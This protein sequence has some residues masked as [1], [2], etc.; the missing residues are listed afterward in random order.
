ML[1]A[2]EGEARRQAAD[3]R[4]L[5]GREPVLL[6]GREFHWRELAAVSRQWEYRRLEALYRIRQEESPVIV[7]TADALALRCIP[8]QV[9]DRCSFTLR[10]DGRYQVEELARRLTAAGYT[11]TEQVEGPGQF[12]LRGGILD[13]YS[14]GAE[15]PV[16]CEFFDDEVDSL[17][18]FDVATQRRTENCREALLLP[19]GEVLPLWRDGAA[20]ETAERLETLAGRMKD[21]PVARQLR[22]DADLLRQG[23]V[24]NG[25]DRFLAAVYPELV[26]AMDYLPAGCLVCVSES[27][28]TAEA[29]KGWLGQLKAD[30]TAAMDSGILCGPMAEAALPE[31]EFARQLERFPVCQLESLPTSRYLLAPKALLQIDARQLS[32]YGGSLETA[33]TDLTHY[34]TGG[35][36]VV[37]LCGGQVRARNLLELLEARRIPAVLDLEGER[38]PVRNVVLITLGT[39]SAGCEYPALQLAVLT[40]GQLT[41]PLAGKSKKTRPKRDSNQQKL[42]S[43]ADLTPGDLVVHQH[44]GVGRFVGMIQDDRGRGGAGLHQDRLCRQRLPVCPGHAAGS[45]EQVYRRRRGTRAHP[46]QQAGRHGLGAQ[47]SQPGQGGRQG[48]GQ[49]AD[50][51]V[52]RA[53]A[54][55]GLRLLSGFPVAARSLRRPSPTTETD[56]QLQA[57]SGRSRADMEQ[58]VP[59]DRLLCGDVGYGKTEVALRAVMKCILDGK[60]AAILVP[61]TV[62]AQQHYATAMNRFR[63]FPV[64]VEVLSRFQHRQADQRNSGASGTGW[65]HRPVDRHP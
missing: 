11:R 45:G 14:P 15:A 7:T 18:F 8:P 26:T 64:T 5:T 1:C 22:S 49:G 50:R 2:D 46:A 59:M 62:L 48:S 63:A 41:T 53:A 58:P 37:V 3:L 13:V 34:L 21:K 31:T 29:L 54:E 28:R 4:S 23:I 30:V 57:A 60:Q 61:T 39:L 12:A 65:K 20:E 9:L 16:R 36:R 44:H 55:G 25:S 32:G 42:Q 43:Y 56:D 47:T 6:T 27:G 10:S 40:E 24:P 17:G 33:V 38:S 19:A 51:A 35:C 52:R